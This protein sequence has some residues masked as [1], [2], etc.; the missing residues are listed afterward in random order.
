MFLY[1]SLGF[2]KVGMWKFSWRLEARVNIAIRGT[3]V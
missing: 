2:P 3:I 1:L